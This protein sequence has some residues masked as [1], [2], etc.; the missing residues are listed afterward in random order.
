MVNFPTR[1]PDCDSHSPAPLDLFISSDTSIC[2]TVAFPPLGNP[3]HVVVSLSIDFPSN[4]QRDALFHCLAYDYSRSD[5][6]SLHDHLKEV[7]WEDIFKLVAYAASNEFCEWVQV[8][9]DVYIPHRKY[10]VKPRSSPWFSAACA[11]ATVHRNHICTKRINFLIL[12]F[13]QASNC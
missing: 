11:V 1:I 5:R 6:D 4:S 10:Q 13:R 7:P 2:Y 3:D 8:G 9:I 12:K